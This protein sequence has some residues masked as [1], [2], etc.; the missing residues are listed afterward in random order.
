MGWADV[1]AALGQ[2]IDLEGIVS[3]AAVLVKDRHLALPHVA[4]PDIRYM[5][6]TELKRKGFR[7]VVFDKDNTI[8][9][10]YS[11]A[12]WGP[13]GSS[14][15]RCKSVFGNDIAVFSNSAGLYEFD[16]D[17]RKAR[18]LEGATGIRVIRHRIK[19]PAGT[20]EEIEKTLWL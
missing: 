14:I 10:P 6:W 20:A 15:E 4:V 12:L 1:K 7:G 9:V 16:P 3:S 2:R 19:K 17:G 13:L 11:L 8:T 5:D 18:A